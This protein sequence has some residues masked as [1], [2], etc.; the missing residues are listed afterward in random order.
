MEVV[1]KQ[2]IEINNVSNVAIKPIWPLVALINFSE[3]AIIFKG[4]MIGEEK[5]HKSKPIKPIWLLSGI[6]FCK[7]STDVIL[8]PLTFVIHWVQI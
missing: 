8:D 5:A 1:L 7:L 4:I 3:I 2:E 6:F